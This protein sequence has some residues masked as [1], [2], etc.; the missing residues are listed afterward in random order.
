MIIDVDRFKQYNDT[1]GHQQGDVALKSIADVLVES[2]KRPGDFVARWG[3]E[4]FVVLLSSTK[5][6][7]AITVAERIRKNIED[8]V[9]PNSADMSDTFATVSIG[10][11]TGI[12]EYSSTVEELLAGADVALYKAKNGGRNRVCAHR[13][14]DI[15][16]PSEEPRK[17]VLVVDADASRLRITKDALSED[18]R[19]T[20][21]SSASEMFVSL[22]EHKPDLILLDADLPGMDGFVA[23]RL[24]KES[25]LHCHI[26]VI[27]LTGR[28]DADNE[29]R[30]IKSGAVD[31]ISKP[32]SIPVLLNRV[33]IHINIDELAQIY[34]ERNAAYRFVDR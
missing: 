6:S 28:G 1:Y 5:L 16:E 32:F 9:I 13:D 7:G 3:G 2:T 26:P 25:S 33:K 17:L 20:A 27:H 34:A 31:F 8:L 30:S 19:V 4:E 29:A 24:L 14:E 15:P 12:D 11:N 18:Y 21:L 22:E 23:I 10:V